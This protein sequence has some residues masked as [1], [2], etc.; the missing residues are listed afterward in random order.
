MGDPKDKLKT[1]DKKTGQPEPQY[2]DLQVRENGTTNQSPSFVPNAATGQRSNSRENFHPVA[3]GQG[4]TTGTTIV[5]DSNVF[6]A[7]LSDGQGSSVPSGTMPERNQSLLIESSDAQGHRRDF[8]PNTRQIPEQELNGMINALHLREKRIGKERW[9]ALARL[10]DFTAD[11]KQRVYSRY[12]KVSDAL[13]GKEKPEGVQEGKIKVAGDHEAEER[14]ADAGLF[15]EGFLLSSIVLSES[16]QGSMSLLTRANRSGQ[17]LKDANALLEKVPPSDGTADF[18]K[19]WGDASPFVSPMGSMLTSGSQLIEVA[20][21]SSISDIDNFGNV[22]AS[23]TKTGLN[24]GGNVASTGINLVNLVS[25]GIALKRN[26]K[27]VDNYERTAGTLGT[28][29]AFL[30]TSSSAV[31]LGHQAG[32]TFTKDPDGFKE[33]HEGKLKLTETIFSGIQTGIDTIAQVTKWLGWGKNKKQ[34]ALAKNKARD[35]KTFKDVNERTFL[36]RMVKLSERRSALSRDKNIISSV[37]NLTDIGSFFTGLFTGGSSD[38]TKGI[39]GLAFG[40]AKMILSGVDSL[41][42][43]IRGKSNRKKL[44]DEFLGITPDAVRERRGNR[45]ISEDTIREEMRKEKLRAI[46]TDEQTFAKRVART[47][48]QQIRHAAFG[49]RSPGSKEKCRWYDSDREDGSGKITQMSEQK[50]GE[51]EGQ[52]NEK[53]VSSGRVSTYLALIRSLG[54]RIRYPSR[55]EVSRYRLGLISDKEFAELYRPSAAAIAARLQ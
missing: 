47:Y 3:A 48:A 30:R 15:S 2:A 18:L 24:L 54:L 9:M 45:D 26:W 44:I 52:E 12:Y 5:H 51:E 43:H 4:Q 19:E 23:A 42:T 16:E 55:K 50:S 49:D 7:P 32:K 14:P 25:S 1:G 22:M 41:V 10:K 39:I 34:R 17:N 6:S 53:P 29:N 37:K 31:S 20:S 11:E 35:S 38:Q 40:G 27:D 33:K 21:Q 46:H 28:L 13:K 8:V 36:Q